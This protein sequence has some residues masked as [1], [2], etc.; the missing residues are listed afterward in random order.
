[1]T[2]ERRHDCVNNNANV[3]PIR[4]ARGLWP[5]PIHDCRFAMRRSAYNVAS[6]ANPHVGPA[7]AP[8]EGLFHGIGSCQV[9][10]MATPTA[11]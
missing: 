2:F 1:M 4:E 9:S 3:G 11:A 6:V 5:V 10:D 8:A 7:R